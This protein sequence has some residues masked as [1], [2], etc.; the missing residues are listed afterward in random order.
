MDM[1]GICAF[2]PKY[3]YA[4]EKRKEMLH[5][6][7][8][9]RVAVWLLG[10][11]CSESNPFLFSFLLSCVYGGRREP[12]FQLLPQTAHIISTFFYLMVS[13]LVLK[14]ERK[15]RYDTPEITF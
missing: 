1:D 11:N 15:R 6:N 13:V 5:Q 8:I 4:E 14:G 2:S 10:N 9:M 7:Q 12:H 3:K